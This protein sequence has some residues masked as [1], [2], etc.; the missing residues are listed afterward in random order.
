MTKSLDFILAEMGSL[1]RVLVTRVTAV[2][3]CFRNIP[4]DVGYPSLVVCGGCEDWKMEGGRKGGRESN[5]GIYLFF[6]GWYCHVY[7]CDFI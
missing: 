7:L 5:E 1:W 2:D 3:F 4:L 6:M